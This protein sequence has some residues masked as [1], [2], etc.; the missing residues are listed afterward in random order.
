MTITTWN[1][2]EPIVDGASVEPG[3]AAPFG[4]PLWLLG[5]QWQIG[6]LSAEDAGTPIAAEVA[7]TTFPID[8]LR[9]G[10]HVRRFDPAVPLEALVEPEP[11][12]PPD[13]RMRLRAGSFL[14]ELVA[15]APAP[16]VAAALPARFPVAPPTDR[17]A[18]A[19]V[20]QLGARAIDGEAA[21]AALA[22]PGAAD[23]LAALE[24]AGGRTAAAIARWLAWY[25][26]R[27]G[28]AAPSAW[29][30][31]HAAYRFALTAAVD[32]REV[33]LEA[34]RYTGGRLDWPELTA[35]RTG[36]AAASTATTR[37]TV[38]LPAPLEIPGG[39][40]RRHFE[41]ED[42]AINANLVAGGPSDVASALLAEVLLL[43]GG[44][45]FVVPV[46]VP[47]GTLAR[48]D[49][50][51][52]TD[53]F[54]VATTRTRRLRSPGW[55]MFELAGDGSLDDFLAILPTIGR[56]VDGAA[57]EELA[58]ARDEAANL[59]WAIERVRPDPLG[60]PRTVEDP[61]PRPLTS[62]D[63]VRWRYQPVTDPPPAWFPLVRRG[64]DLTGARGPAT[65]TAHLLAGWPGVSLA[66]EDVPDHGL[67][68][69]RRYQLATARDGRRF[70]WLARDRHHGAGAVASSAFAD[71]LIPPAR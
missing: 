50:I 64:R 56:P 36:A 71:T 25:R 41:L 17:T 69:A 14:H 27:T 43:H 10:D 9:V 3:L 28:R 37:T 62:D 60:L 39:P 68:L 13:L 20:R 52:V 24:P 19:L 31:E 22:A 29:Q 59:A 38:L 2:I 51:T 67:R 55:R 46:D 70:L 7:V 18:A 12:A 57:I 63:P 23:A 30:P 44:D 1:R 54:G 8:G 32:G 53:T 16:R 5:R 45:W 21:L 15:A 4:D 26:E 66:A 33:V 65:P 6:E 48:I 40:A 34:E 49:R 42:R 11:P 61:P 35:R 58:I 47:V